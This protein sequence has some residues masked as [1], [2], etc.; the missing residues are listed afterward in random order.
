MPIERMYLSFIRPLKEYSDAVWDNC[1]SESKK[2]LDLIH[3]EAARIMTGG[4]TKLC[5]IQ[6]LYLSWDW[7]LCKIEEHKLLIFYKIITGLIQAYLSDLLPHIVKD[8]VTYNLRN[9]TNMQPLRVRTNLFV[10]LSFHQPF[11]PGM[12]YQM[13]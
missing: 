9:A 8:N 10:T 7:I 6:K 4:R 12:S 3:H 1:P 11:V 2:Q 13:K 5:S